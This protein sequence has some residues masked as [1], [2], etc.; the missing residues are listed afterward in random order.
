MEI[1][2]FIF[3]P[4]GHYGYP[5]STDGD[6]P[7]DYNTLVEEY[8]G[9]GY[10]AWNQG[11]FDLDEEPDSDDFETSEEYDEAYAEWEESQK[12]YKE[13]CY[14]EYGSFD[15][16]RNSYEM[17]ANPDIGP[18]DILNSVFDYDGTSCHDDFMQEAANTKGVVYVISR[19]SDD[20]IAIAGQVYPFNSDSQELSDVLSDNIVK[21]YRDK[22]P[23]AGVIYKDI[24]S[25]IQG[26]EEKVISMLSPEE[27]DDLN[28][29]G[30]GGSMLRRF[31][32][33]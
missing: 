30:K 9:S 11:D 19:G 4:D 14:D 26:V 1:K 31:G 33:F 13:D 18:D 15:V 20:E 10:S 27:Y 22:N 16:F 29:M 3:V 8:C 23:K 21:E 12:S 28:N 6:T 2:K 25:N 5:E 7:Y 32:S 17:V 24:K